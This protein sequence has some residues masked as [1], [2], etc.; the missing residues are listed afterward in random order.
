MIF[1]AYACLVVSLAALFI[2]GRAYCLPKRY[3]SVARSGGMVGATATAA[4]ALLE[5]STNHPSTVGRIAVLM[6]LV[7]SVVYLAGL[8]LWHERTGFVLRLTG[9]ILAAAGLAIPSTLTLLLPVIALLA[10]TLRPESA[11]HAPAGRL[12]RQ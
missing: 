8:A 3:E 2:R 1:L 11:A 7:G 9:W 4:I 6:L 12:A 10:L 5:I